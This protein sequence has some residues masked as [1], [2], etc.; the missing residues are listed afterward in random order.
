[1]ADITVQV[2]DISLF[3]GEAQPPT[4]AGPT[5]PALPVA[6]MDLASLKSLVDKM[7]EIIEIREGVRGSNFD[8][9]ITWR[10]LFKSGLTKLTLDGVSYS[11]DTSTP[12]GLITNND[13]SPPPAPS[14]VAGTSGL[15]VAIITWNDPAYANLAYAEVWRSVTNSIGTSVLN[16]TT[17]SNIFTDAIGATNVT[18]FYW[19]RLVSVNNIVGPFNA[20]TGVSVNTSRV[21][22]SDVSDLLITAAKLADSAV[23]SIKLSDG[24]IITSKIADAAIVGAKMAD[25]AVSAAK[26]AANSVE[27]DKIAA[28]AVLSG[29]LADLA[30]EA[31]KL[32]DSAVTAVKIANLAVGTAAIADAAI[33]SAKIADLGVTTAKIADASIVSAKIAA[34]A[35]GT[36]AI[37]D[38]AINSAKIAALAVGTAAIADAAIVNAKIGDL[39]VDTGKI[40]DAAIATA[41]IADAAI[42][43]AKITD[44][45][46]TTAKIDDAAITTAKIG[47]AAITSAKIGD[48]VI[49]TAKIAETIQS[50]NFSAA[51]LVGWQITKAGSIQM[52]GGATFR[53]DLDIKSAASGAR[54]EIA[55]TVIKV[56]DSAGAVRVKLGNLA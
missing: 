41:K 55:N 9:Y 51:T 29:K 22:T 54:M 25:L 1:M 46:I 13:F 30:V 56:F 20:I 14:G 4:G 50:T 18:Y 43:S 34:L 52:Y 17:R 10:D 27:S 23:T 26:L 19:V 5:L 45:S 24:S 12:I 3:L 15:A 47:D 7:K 39:A 48:A 8:R 53:G 40:A 38:A 11:A 36:A 28:G 31:A 37:Q 21:G 44:A 35:V 49:T 42:T 2:D 32:A 6:T 33:S 16:G